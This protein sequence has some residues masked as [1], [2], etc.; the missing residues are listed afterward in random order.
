VMKPKPVFLIIATLIIGF[1]LGM[2][3]SAQIRYHKLNPVR[4]YFSEDRFR[5]GFYQAIQPD[6]LQKEKIDLVLDKYARINSELQNSFRKELEASMKDFR[7]EIDTYLTKGQQLRLKEMDERREQMIIRNR[8]DHEKDSFD[9]RNN[10]RHHH[11]LPPFPDDGQVTATPHLKDSTVL[12]NN[13]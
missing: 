8:K 6:E 9:Y 3:T 2:L 1:V 4:V 13:K 5:D 11:D 10:R 7:K 12:H